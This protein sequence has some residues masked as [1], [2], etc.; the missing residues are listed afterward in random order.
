MKEGQ[1]TNLRSYLGFSVV[2]ALMVAW[3]LA[4]WTGF[5]L[6]IFP[7]TSGNSSHALLLGFTRA[8]WGIM[9][10]WLSVIAVFVTVVEIAISWKPIMEGIGYL[11]ETRGERTID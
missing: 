2:T 5:L 6:G 3:I 7:E 4:A 1:S 8:E 9:H 11:T 10:Y